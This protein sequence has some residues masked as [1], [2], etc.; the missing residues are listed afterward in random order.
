MPATLAG[1]LASISELLTETGAIYAVAFGFVI[2]FT[3]LV[4][5]RFRK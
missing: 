5:R 4:I 3:S 2:A 1:W